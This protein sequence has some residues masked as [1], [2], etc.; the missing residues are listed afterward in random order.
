VSDQI[1][2]LIDI[3]SRVGAHATTVDLQLGGDF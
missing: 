3:L 2:L 1:W